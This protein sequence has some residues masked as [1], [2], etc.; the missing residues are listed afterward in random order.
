MAVLGR[1]SGPIQVDV[2]PT[3]LIYE[4]GLESGSVSTPG[5]G[6]LVFGG[7][8]GDWILAQSPPPHGGGD[9]SYGV[10]GDWSL[11]QSGPG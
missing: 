9:L 4:G 1:L 3:R 8:G 7:G 5:G 10:K 11:A 6:D 2:S